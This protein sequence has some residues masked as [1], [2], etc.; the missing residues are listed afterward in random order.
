MLSEFNILSSMTD[1]YVIYIGQGKTVLTAKLLNHVL[2]NVTIPNTVT[3]YHFF[4]YRTENT[5][6]ASVM[7]RSIIDQIVDEQYRQQL[8]IHII[9]ASCRGQNLPEENFTELWKL[10]MSIT[11]C[12]RSH[13]IRLLILIDA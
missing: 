1:S 12:L 8:L 2:K 9:R 10:F 6:S 5:T 13:S 7:L 11:K 4:N 3:V